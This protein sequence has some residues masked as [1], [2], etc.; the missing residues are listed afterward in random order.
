MHTTPPSGST[1]SGGPVDTARLAIWRLFHEGYIDEDMA[2]ASLL[3]V[4][5]GMRRASRH[6][7]SADNQSRG[8]SAAAR[9]D[10]ACRPQPAA[11]HW[12]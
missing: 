7:L 1:G 10:A 4:D 8:F 3:A 12:R 11:P 6:K 9:T 5:V 2:T